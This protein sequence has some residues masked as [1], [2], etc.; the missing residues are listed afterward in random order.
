M[1][2]VRGVEFEWLGGFFYKWALR[3]SLVA[4]FQLRLSWQ[5]YLPGW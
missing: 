5:H 4:N 1:D 3:Q 2:P